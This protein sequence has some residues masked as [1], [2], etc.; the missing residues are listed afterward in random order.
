MAVSKTYYSVEILYQHEAE[1]IRYVKRNIREER[2]RE[3]REG[4][5]SAGVAII[6][7]VGHWAIVLPWQIKSINIYRQDKWIKED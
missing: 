5:I 1:V 2:L 7:G 6:R 4:I 3:F